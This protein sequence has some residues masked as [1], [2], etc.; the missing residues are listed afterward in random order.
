MKPIRISIRGL[1]SFV[2]EQVIDFEK[3][4]RQGIFGIFGPTGSGKST[5]LDAIT[6]ALYGQIAR[7]RVKKDMHNYINA[8][9]TAARVVFEF[10]INAH[11]PKVYKLIREAKRK[12]TDKEHPAY[13]SAQTSESKLLCL[14]DDVV[15]ADKEG[16]VKEEISK[17][18]GLSYD[19]FVKTVVLPQGGFQDFLQMNGAE[20]GNILERLFGLEKYG[21][22]LENKLKAANKKTELELSS[23][24]G[25]LS[26]FGE[27]NEEAVKEKEELL[28]KLTEDLGFLEKEKEALAAKFERYKAVYELQ[29]NLAELE[30]ALAEEKERTPEIEKLE[31]EVR[32]AERAGLLESPMKSYSDFREKRREAEED[33]KQKLISFDT[34]EAE[35]KEAEHA[36]GAMDQE[37]KLRLPGLTESLAQ[38]KQALERWQNFSSYKKRLEE[39][40]DEK[41]NLSK[42]LKLKEE[43]RLEV[44][45]NHKYTLAEIET[46]RSFIKENKVSSERRTLLVEALTISDRV[47]GLRKQLKKTEEDSLLKEEKLT[48]AAKEEQDFTL[49]ER[50]KKG[51]LED[52][53]KELQ[54]LKEAPFADA[55]Y[56][57]E[58]KQR[59][60]TRMAG[61][62]EAE[63][64]EKDIAQLQALLDGL[65]NKLEEMD[66]AWEVLDQNYLDKKAEYEDYILKRSVHIIRAGLHEGE[67]CPV[68]S[69]IVTKLDFGGMEMVESEALQNHLKEE[70]DRLEL[71]RR[72]LST[73]KKELELIGQAHLKRKDELQAEL[74][75]GKEGLDKGGLEQ[76]LKSLEEDYAQFLSALK[77]LED[78]EKGLESELLVL[79]NKFKENA[80]RAQELRDDFA[81]LSHQKQDLEAEIGGLEERIEEL[82][83]AEAPHPK[84]ELDA[85][86]KKQ[87]EIDEAGERLEGLEKAE[88]KQSAEL[89]RV[90]E[91][92]GESRIALAGLD[93][94]REEIRI[95]LSK[96]EGYLTGLLGEARDPRP[97]L[98]DMEQKLVNLEGAY[99]KAKTTKEEKEAFYLEAERVRAVAEQQL[100]SLEDLF[101]KSK[102]ELIQKM[103]I[104]EI[105]DF[106]SVS[107]EKLEEVLEEHRA[108]LS[109]QLLTEQEKRERK[110]KIDQHRAFLSKKQGEIE[111]VKKRMKGEEVSE[112]DFLALTQDFEAMKN[113][114][115]ESFDRNSREKN[116][117]EKMKVA[118]ERVKEIVAKLE[119]LKKRSHLLAELMKVIKSRAFAEFMA[120]KQL[121]YV[122]VKA[123][124]ILSSITNGAYYLEAD[125]AGNFK[126]RDNLNGGKL[127]DVR[128]LS[129]GETF[130][131]SLSL[132]LA[133]S[134]QIQL[135]GVAPLELFFLDEGFGT[136]DKDRLDVI[137]DA[138]ERMHHDRLKIGIISHVEELKQRIPI[139]L[140]IS[141]AKTEEGGSRAKIEYS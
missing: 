67:N 21:N 64:K 125:E 79:G 42:Q 38:L 108:S 29:K 55:G 24:T 73:K 52:L 1:N 56:Y 31:E 10:E 3:L 4:S 86:D 47:S 37:Y 44:L 98:S 87:R 128:T 9:C 133:L 51:L 80:K 101:Q 113:R 118:W 49:S 100:Q 82:M 58:E 92:L 13:N 121:D 130:I 23:Q 109:L 123:T 33:L 18:L 7:N 11:S 14:T 85:L 112:E 43:L 140:V 99:N 75:A 57:F 53:K 115:L 54:S 12:S 132:A 45:K 66:G 34:R 84:A 8:Q 30:L 117:Y 72:E 76:G 78:G 102:T 6:F 46:L 120:L 48:Q 32:N 5:V 77:T 68:C 110:N 69:H 65:Q 60:M 138:L 139:K 83:G 20:R 103:E 63:K 88:S 116:E 90:E 81:A 28:N 93:T 62:E 16:D 89:K 19:D 136:L 40:E 27:I 111:S 59:L 61:Q 105:A 127:R 122:S 114:Y 74:L 129:G 94:R 96:E 17:I 137:M 25:A 50:E 131:V 71:E 119:E 26:S 97:D 41:L 35:R 124:E 141:K 91:E 134:A 15:L 107:G 106:S 135:K 2:E 36:F 22:G 70:L 39:V 104:L 126:V 95:L